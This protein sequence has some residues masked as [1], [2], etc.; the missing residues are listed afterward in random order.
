MFHE[1]SAAPTVE[2]FFKKSVRRPCFHEFVVRGKGEEIGRIPDA[3][4]GAI[5]Y[6]HFDASG[7]P[8]Q[9]VVDVYQHPAGSNGRVRC[10]MLGPNAEL[11][12]YEFQG[13]NDTLPLPAGRIA[14]HQS[15]WGRLPWQRHGLAKKLR[16]AY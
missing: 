7:R 4:T 9:V 15:W 5:R 11:S 13:S 14:T 12:Y 6:T 1:I 8:Q 3:G 2:N 16:E 10:S